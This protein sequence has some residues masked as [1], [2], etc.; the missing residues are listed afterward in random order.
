MSG[1]KY[2]PYFTRDELLEIISTLKSHPSPRRL[3]ICKYL[4]GF[5]LKITHGVIQSAHTP[6][7][8]AEEKLG[9]APIP[10]SHEVTGEAAYQKWLLDP[11]K[12]TPKEIE[13]AMD[14]RYR[15]NLMSPT[16]EAEYESSQ[17]N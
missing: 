5:M 14:W 8:T 10:V 17:L 12:A 13:E 6:Q 2:R 7:P 1:A 11:A 3:Q 9:F 15:N 16:E 4:E